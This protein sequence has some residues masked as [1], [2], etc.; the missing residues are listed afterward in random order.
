MQSTAALET[1]IDRW[2]EAAREALSL[3]REVGSLDMGQIATD[4][5]DADLPETDLPEAGDPADVVVDRLIAESERVLVQLGPHILGDLDAGARAT[6]LLVADLEA[7]HAL[8]AGGD[9]FC[10]RR[11]RICG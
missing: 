6:A 1:S 5:F 2:Q 10:R 11:L 8:L 9:E 4:F 7:T 3:A